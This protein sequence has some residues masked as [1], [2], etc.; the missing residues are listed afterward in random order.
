MRTIDFA[1]NQS[2]NLQPYINFSLTNRQTTPTYDYSFDPDSTTNR[3]ESIEHH[4]EKFDDY[5][6][7][8]LN[9]YDLTIP[10]LRGYLVDIGYGVNVSGTPHYSNTARLWVENQYT[11]SLPN[12]FKT[13]LEL[14]GIW[15]IL[16]RMPLQIGT[17][18]YYLDENDVLLTKTVYELME[19]LIETVL[20]GVTGQ[21][22]TLSPLGD[23]DDG[24]ISSLVPGEGARPQKTETYAHYIDSIM[25]MT[26]CYLRAE[27]GLNFRVMWPQEG[28]GTDKNYYSDITYGHVYYDLRD[29]KQATIPNHVI[30]YANATILGGSILDWDDII[31]AHAYSS[32]DFSSPPTYDG[33]Y[34]EIPEV[35]LAPGLTTQGQADVHAANILSLAKALTSEGRVIVPHDSARE[36]YDKILLVDSRSPNITYYPS[37]ALTRVNSLVHRWQSGGSGRKPIYQLEIGLGGLSSA[38]SFPIIDTVEPIPSVTPP[39]NATTTTV[40]PTVTPVNGVTI[41]VTSTTTKVDGTMTPIWGDDKGTSTIMPPGYY[42][43]IYNSQARYREMLEKLKNLGK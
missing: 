36:L 39:S 11:I 29:R 6:T 18:P 13:V 8:V 7:V 43:D 24:V 12:N 31:T 27:A 9:N 20:T 28:D 35:Y 42:K 41:N 34:M 3:L 25:S 4:E 26:S 5:A 19:Y 15:H 30:V 10:D 14:G 16:N 23:Q 21:F 32:E 22:F 17:A 37:S 38:I 2:T 1:A 33:P 40:T